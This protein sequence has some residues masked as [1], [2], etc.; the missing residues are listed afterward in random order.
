[1]NA[2]YDEV[3]DSHG[4]GDN[5]GVSTDFPGNI[6]VLN[7]AFIYHHLEPVNRLQQPLQYFRRALAL[8]YFRTTKKDLRHIRKSWLLWSLTGNLISAFFGANPTMMK[9]NF[10]LLWKISLNKNP[11][12]MAHKKNEKVIEPK[13]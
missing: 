8:D 5:Y 11:Y 12:S 3:L 10:K 9:A 7:H 6:H 13:L 4:I 1:L 2:P